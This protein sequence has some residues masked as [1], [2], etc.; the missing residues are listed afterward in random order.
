MQGTQVWSLVKEVRSL[1][2][3]G[4]QAHALWS[5]STTTREMFSHSNKTA[6]ICTKTQRHHINL[7]KKKDL[8]KNVKSQLHLYAG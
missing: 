4:N 3:Q 2:L 6:H 5:P 8:E 1:M 7:K